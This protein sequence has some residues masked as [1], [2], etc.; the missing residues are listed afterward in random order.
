MKTDVEV[1]PTKYHRWYM[2]FEAKILSPLHSQEI[3]TMHPR[4][5]LGRRPPSRTHIDEA[6]YAAL[7][8]KAN[9]ETSTAYQ[10]LNTHNIQGI[11]CNILSALMNEQPTDP[12]EF[13]ISRLQE[14]QRIVVKHPILTDI[15]P[16]ILQRIDFL[17]FIGAPA[18]GKTTIA[19]QL[20]HKMRQRGYLAFHISEQDIIHPSE[21]LPPP[22]RDTVNTAT[23]AGQ[24]VPPHI[25]KQLCLARVRAVIAKQSAFPGHG[26]LKRATVLLD[27]FPRQLQEAAL[28]DR[29]LEP[30]CV[31]HVQQPSSPGWLCSRLPYDGVGSLAGLRW[32]QKEWE[33]HGEELVEYYSQ[34]VQSAEMVTISGDTPNGQKWAYGFHTVWPNVLRILEI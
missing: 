19:L 26:K 2:P 34:A 28:L 4:R 10:Y 30:R 21:G 15:T 5:R 6:E 3:H 22:Y 12:W 24:T 25:A 8:M 18:V 11:M 7:R 17:Y 9:M 20:R 16:S 31:F 1:C 29:T 14:L 23:L 33:R 27:G 32:R 13:L